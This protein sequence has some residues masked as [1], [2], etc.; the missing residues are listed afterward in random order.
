MSLTSGPMNEAE[1]AGEKI[2]DHANQNLI[3]LIRELFACLWRT[4]ITI[5]I[6][7]RKP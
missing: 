2:I 5:D 1:Q 7:E 3:G 4:R 6:G